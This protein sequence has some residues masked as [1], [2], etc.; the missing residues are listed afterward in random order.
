MPN[1][2]LQIAKPDGSGGNDIPG[3]GAGLSFIIFLAL[4]NDF[5]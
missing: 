1:T 3:L 2:R 5:D 4:M